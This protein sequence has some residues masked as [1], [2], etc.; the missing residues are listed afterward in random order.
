VFHSS[1]YIAKEF[2][3]TIVKRICKEATSCI[4]KLYF[5]LSIKFA[6]NCSFGA[7]RSIR[8]PV[9]NFMQPSARE[10]QAEIRVIYQSDDLRNEDSRNPCWCGEPFT[11]QSG[12][13]FLRL[14]CYCF[15]HCS[16]LTEYVKSC[17]KDINHVQ[18]WGLPFPFADIYG[19]RQQYQR[20][21]Y[22]T[23]FDVELLIKHEKFNGES[24]SS[25][26]QLR[27]GEDIQILTSADVELF[28][29]LQQQKCILL[30]CCCHLRYEDLIDAIHAGLVP[31]AECSSV[32]C[33]ISRRGGDC[34]GKGRMSINRNENV[35]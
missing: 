26:D 32:K 10:I 18:E 17:A 24:T 3:N 31:V 5:S 1:H 25:L 16:C 9:N 27:E 23:S 15:V 19:F 29:S 12:A 13:H 4:F 7:G 8:H 14:G 34:L 2:I 22:I 35:P 21:G 28:K 30:S 20:T 33:P 11:A 6:K